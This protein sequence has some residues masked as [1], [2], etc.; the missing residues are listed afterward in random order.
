LVVG[1]QNDR[2]ALESVWSHALQRLAR[3]DELVAGAGAMSGVVRDS[4]AV[5]ERRRGNDSTAVRSVLDAAVGCEAFTL[6]TLRAVCGRSFERHAG[7][8][9]EL[10]FVLAGRGELIC[11]GRHVEL[12]PQTGVRLEA[13]A[14]YELDNADATDLELVSVSLHHPLTQ[15]GATGDP[16]VSRLADRPA[17]AA[18]GD[19][20]FRIVFDADSGCP[21]ATQ[22]VGEIPVG[23]A[24]RHYHLY[25]EVIYVLEG[26]G[27][28]HMNAA[29]TPLHPG[30]AIH[31]PSRTLHTL[32]NGG[33]GVMR[34]LGVFS[35]AGS[36]AAA[37]YPDGTPA[38]TADDSQTT[39]ATR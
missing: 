39:A 31:L 36:P 28:M 37:F 7:A 23:A 27:V 25:E 35:P 1:P 11:G 34:V 13:G 4:S 32:E 15:L 14:R 24:P 22:F 29:H 6:R 26:H 33:P 38:Y 17:Q 18:T 20:T 8:A 3:W 12:E 2:G 19:R 21:T 16:G 10:L 9:Q 30:T 5:A